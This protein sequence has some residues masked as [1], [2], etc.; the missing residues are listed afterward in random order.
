M[1]PEMMAKDQTRYITPS[2]PPATNQEYMEEDENTPITRKELAHLLKGKGELTEPTWKIN[3]P[4]GNHQELKI[5]EFSKSLTGRAFTWVQ[6][7]LCVDTLPESQLVYRCIRNA[8]DGFQI[9]LSMNNINTFSELLKR[10]SDITEAMKCS[11]RRLKSS[12][13]RCHNQGRFRILCRLKLEV[14]RS[15][16]RTNYENDM[17]I[18]LQQENVTEFATRFKYRVRNSGHSP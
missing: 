8:E 2:P 7:L 4:F 17:E 1:D 9:Y 18:V 14:H 11:G 10:A 15:G 13:F 12:R 5:K 6:A 16:T 3:P